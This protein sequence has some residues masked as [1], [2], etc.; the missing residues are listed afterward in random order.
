MDTNRHLRRLSV[1]VATH[2]ESNPL[3]FSGEPF[4]HHVPASVREVR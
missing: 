4:G 3:D 2:P 1:T